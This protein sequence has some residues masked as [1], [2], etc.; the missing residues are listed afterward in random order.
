MTNIQK[1]GKSGRGRHCF[2]P[3][4]RSST[5]RLQ[6]PEAAA[7]KKSDHEESNIASQESSN[8]TPSPCQNSSTT[9]FESPVH[10][11]NCIRT[12]T[13]SVSRGDLNRGG[14]AGS[15]RSPAVTV[16]PKHWL[17]HIPNRSHTLTCC[18]NQSGLHNFRGPLKG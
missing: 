17:E 3:L 4:Y 12:I 7:D 13:K 6:I 1:K 8:H 16:L 9:N 11:G 14:V 5:A 15:I 10:R 2:T 18:F